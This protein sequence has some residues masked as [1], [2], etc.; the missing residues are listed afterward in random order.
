MRPDQPC[1]GS[2]G[3]V[4]GNFN[5]VAAGYASGVLSGGQNY[6]CDS[7]TAISGGI[8]NVISPASSLSVQY[9]AIGAGEDNT[10]N[11]NGNAAFIGGGG[12]NS[13][14][15]TAG[16]IGAGS[17]NFINQ[18][19][20]TNGAYAAVI[21]GGYQNVVGASGANIAGYGAIGGGSYNQVDG[22]DGTVGGGNRNGANATY[23]SVLG[24][25]ANVASG[26]G[27]MVPGG[28]NNTAA[29]FTSLAAGYHAYAATGAFVWSD[30]S[31][32]AITKSTATNQFLARVA[33]GVTF[34]TNSAMTTGVKVAAGGGS[35]SSASD[36]NLKTAY[37]SIDADD[38]LDKV[39]LLPIGTWSYISEPGVRHVG[40]MAQDFYA[41]FGVGEDNRHITTIDEDGIALAAIQALHRENL[42]LRRENLG[43]RHANT[44]LSQQLAALRNQQFADHRQ[45]ERFIAAMA[46]K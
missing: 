14:N 33:G 25:S 37:R 6:A 21:G 20:A 35:W 12:S 26:T 7:Y 46:K 36:R 23:S 18:N 30:D 4:G 38:V 5:N 45:L 39:S 8:S 3:F 11:G 43:L 31:S 42:G 17:G 15:A 27:S 22:Q 32:S 41:A 10:I 24:G 40:P 1:S 34:W 9:A 16:F 29:G 19:G 44:S 28:S 13:V 2:G